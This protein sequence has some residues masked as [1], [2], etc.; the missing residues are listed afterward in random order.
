MDYTRSLLFFDTAFRYFWV[1]NTFWIQKW[2]WGNF[3][4]LLL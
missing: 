3:S 2:K 4:D 1:F